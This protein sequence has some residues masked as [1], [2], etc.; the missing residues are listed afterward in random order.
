[1]QLWTVYVLE[2]GN[3]D[4]RKWAAKPQEKQDEFWKAYEQ[5]ICFQEKDAALNND[6][7]IVY[8]VDFDGYNLAHY[9]SEGGNLILNSRFQMI[10]KPMFFEA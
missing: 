2:F 7:G 4:F 1:M 10:S 5:R 6:Q 8:I 9:A 3:F